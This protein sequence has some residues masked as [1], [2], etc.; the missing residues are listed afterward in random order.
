MLDWPEQIQ[1]S[2]MRTSLIVSSLS[3]LIVMVC[4]GALPSSAAGGLCLTL[5]SPLA[6]AVASA[7]ADQEDLTVIFSPGLA[8]PQSTESDFCWKI[9]PPLRTAGSLTS[10]REEEHAAARAKDDTN[11]GI[12]IRA[13]YRDRARGC[14]TRW[15]AVRGEDARAH[16]CWASSA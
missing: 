12:F 3:P 1:R 4:G 2:P 13:V 15:V 14:R 16:F 6:S 10:A 8:Q 5:H 11:C 7:E 9:M